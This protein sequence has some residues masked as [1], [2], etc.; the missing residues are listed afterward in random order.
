MSLFAEV[1]KNLYEKNK[2]DST[3]VYDLLVCKK[4]TKE[5]YLAIL[6]KETD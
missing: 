5:E 3:K 6:G 4:I 1:I 2:I